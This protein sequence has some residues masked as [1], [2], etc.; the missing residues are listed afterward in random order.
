MER[1]QVIGIIPTTNLALLTNTERQE[2]YML[3]MKE[4]SL[5]RMV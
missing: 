1:I 4:D 3:D 5:L 2:G